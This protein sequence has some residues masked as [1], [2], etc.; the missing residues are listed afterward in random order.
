MTY[1]SEKYSDIEENKFKDVL[2]KWLET[3]NILKQF[4]T[5]NFRCFFF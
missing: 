5:N 4:L 1:E 2:E 3:E